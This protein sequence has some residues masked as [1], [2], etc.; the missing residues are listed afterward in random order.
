VAGGRRVSCRAL[1]WDRSCRV[2]ASC[3]VTAEIP[4]GTKAQPHDLAL[5]LLEAGLGYGSQLDETL[6]WDDAAGER[7]GHYEQ[8]ARQARAGL[9]PLW[10]GEK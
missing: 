3:T 1:K 10:L 4:A 2:V 8:L 5:Q 7:Y 6:P 9:W